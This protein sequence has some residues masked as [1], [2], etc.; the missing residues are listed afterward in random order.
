[1]PALFTST[2]MGPP[3]SSAAIASATAFASVTSKASALPPS[4]AARDCA[5]SLLRFACTITSQPSAAS[6]RQMAVPIAPLPPV[7]SARL[8]IA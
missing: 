6:R 4:S 8:F 1:M 2:W 3:S 7:T 5:A